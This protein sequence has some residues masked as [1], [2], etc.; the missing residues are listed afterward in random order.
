MRTPRGEVLLEKTASRGAKGEELVWT[1]T[2]EE[3]ELIRQA[4]RERMM[5]NRT[6]LEDGMAAR[7]EVWRGTRDKKS[8]EWRATE[9]E[10]RIEKVREGPKKESQKSAPPEPKR[11]RQAKVG[12]RE[13][14]AAIPLHEKPLPPLRRKGLE[15]IFREDSP[16][17]SLRCRPASNP[18]VGKSKKEEQ[19]E[20]EARRLNKGNFFPEICRSGSKKQEEK[21]EDG[22]ISP[23]R[24]LSR[25][26]GPK[27]HV[28]TGTASRKDGTKGSGH[29]I[30]ALKSA[31]DFIKVRM[32]LRPRESCASFVCADAAAIE[33]GQV[34]LRV[35]LGEDRI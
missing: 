35:L 19:K 23:R 18:V 34:P 13:I 27:L 16:P 10:S 21:E 33:R 25:R 2:R 1:K 17:P 28:D 22:H 3:V 30:A 7:K 6:G 31:I 14:R 15:N 26:N 29:H 12:N 32:E 20:K 24:L 9:R 4:R 11:E 8:K 5:G